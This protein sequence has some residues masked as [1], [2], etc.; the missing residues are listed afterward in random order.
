MDLNDSVIFLVPSH[1]NLIG[2][3]L[4]YFIVAAQYFSLVCC[5]LF[6]CSRLLT[7]AR[8]ALVCSLLKLLSIG[9]TMVSSH[10]F[11]NFFNL[12]HCLSWNIVEREFRDMLSNFP[13]QSQAIPGGSQDL[14]C[15]LFST[16]RISNSFLNWT[17]LKTYTDGPAFIEECVSSLYWKIQN[18]FA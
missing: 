16:K 17:Q 10:H 4:H 14:T 8:S 5:L 15:T 6:F 11:P 3:P 12:I 9:Q 13:L 7:R 2:G 1:A 18:I